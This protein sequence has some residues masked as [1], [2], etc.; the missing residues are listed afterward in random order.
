LLFGAAQLFALARGDGL[1]VEDVA[2]GK[3]ERAA[4]KKSRDREGCD[5]APH[6]R[7]SR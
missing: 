7:P 4:G 6:W 5:R 3:S 2:L 1:R